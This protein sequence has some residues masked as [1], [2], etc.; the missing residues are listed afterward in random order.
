MSY[1]WLRK[2]DEGVRYFVE[3]FLAKELNISKKKKKN[4]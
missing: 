1:Y 4:I 2:L 3:I